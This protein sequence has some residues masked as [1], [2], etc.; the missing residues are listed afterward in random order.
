MNHSPGLRWSGGDSDRRIPVRRS[1]S[2]QPLLAQR[3]S[4]L[5][6]IA[7]MRLNFPT[8]TGEALMAT[9]AVKINLDHVAAMAAHQ[10]ALREN[11]SLTN[12]ANQ[13]IREA[14]QRRLNAP[15]ESAVPTPR[16]NIKQAP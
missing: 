10:V 14:W 15:S 5:R 11:R 7:H 13:L 4:P 16:A 9:T 1:E 2:P 12:A 6:F 8:F 3:G